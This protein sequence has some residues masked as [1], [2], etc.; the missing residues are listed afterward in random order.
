MP[1]LALKCLESWKTFLP[2]YT[3]MVWN[4]E[5]F[6]L[7]SHPFTKE[8]YEA[9]K[10]AFITDYVRLWALKEYGGVYMDTDVEVLKPLD[11]F[12]EFPAFSGFE[13]ETH[14]PTGIMASEKGGKW[15]TE[16]LA[17]YDNRHFKKPDGSL[18]TTTNVTIMCENMS[19]QGFILKNSRQNFKNI[20][21]IFPKDYFCPKSY[22]TGKIKLTSNT[23]TIHHFAGSWY[24]PWQR[25]K[26]FIKPY[27]YKL[28]AKND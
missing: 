5:T 22:K 6:D 12:L 7:N 21:E 19:K 18:D 15:V 10:Y 17:Y 13:D 1:P 26:R 3:V 2:E 28:L 14:I 27:I 24:T 9:K 25:F 11:K 23:H 16:Q 20:I 8:A 4:E